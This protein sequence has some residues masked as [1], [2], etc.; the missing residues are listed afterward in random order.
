MSGS[1]RGRFHGGAERECA[2]PRGLAAA[3]GCAARA[4]LLNAAFLCGRTSARRRR[5]A[6]L[7]HHTPLSSGPLSRRGQS[8]IKTRM[9]HTSMTVRPI[10]PSSSP[11]PSCHC[12]PNSDAVMTFFGTEAF[13]NRF[14]RF[15]ADRGKGPGTGLEMALDSRS[16]FALQVGGRGTSS[17]G[18]ARLI[19]P[20][21]GGRRWPPGACPL[22]TVRVLTINGLRLPSPAMPVTLSTGMCCIQTDQHDKALVS[23]WTLRLD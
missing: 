21:P 4:W 14:Q 22:A 19:H 23:D 16:S 20:G 3:R 11:G 15:W 10:S 17:L 18:R 13:T 6:S 5:T 7:T 8:A 12:C 2:A 9:R 1:P